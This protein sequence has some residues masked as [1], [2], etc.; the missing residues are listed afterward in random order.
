MRRLTQ[1][2]EKFTAHLTPLRSGESPL[3]V[4]SFIVIALL[5]SMPLILPTHM[6]SGYIAL[7]LI[8]SIISV[9]LWRGRNFSPQ[10][11]LIISIAI[12]V[13]LF[14]LLPFTSNDSERYLW[15]GA[16]FLNGFDPYIYAPND[17]A[18]SD[19][20][21][22][23][24][25]PEEHANYATLYPPGA[26]TLFSICALAGPVYGIWVWKGILA[27]S[28]VISLI[29]LQKLLACR[30]NIKAFSLFAFSP[31]FLFEAQ[32]GAHL[33][34]ICVLGIVA[35][36]YSIEKNALITAGIIIGLAAT[37]KFL[38]AVIIGP[39]LFYLK[40]RRALYLCLSA[41]F[42]W[43]SLYALMFGLGYKPLGLLP[44]FFEKWR[45]GAPIYPLLEA[46]Q[47]T[48][49]LSQ[50][51][52]FSLLAALAV[53][54]F[55]LSAWLAKRGHINIAIAVSLAVPLILSPVLFPWYLLM[56]LPL[57]ALRPNM[58]LFVTITLVPFSYEV[59]DKWLSIGQWSQAAWPAYILL[60][61]IICGLLFDL[62][63]RRYSRPVQP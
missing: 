62:T 12:C 39:F 19:L 22:L 15:D 45:G 38:P 5:Y 7:S 31:L 9:L 8:M 59:L 25:T 47:A 17:A 20:R 35:G 51:H 56:L 57:L 3:Y 29:F 55:T 42:T 43:I 26:L 34:I 50:I 11:Q 13:L 33:D 63:Q 6:G 2:I 24:P 1:R 44:T 54:G 61:A 60:I 28:A 30:G 4:L 52:F 14:P 37:V 48:L 46:V 23:W 10:N 58:T 18:L 49:K 21:A 16:V 36:L 40:P 27:A 53:T 41:A 32:A